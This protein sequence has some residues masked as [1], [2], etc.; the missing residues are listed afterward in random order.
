VALVAVGGS[1]VRCG[2]ANALDIAGALAATYQPNQGPHY[3]YPYTRLVLE[4]L[5]A[6][7]CTCAWPQAAC[8]GLRS[9]AGTV[10][11]GCGCGAAPLSDPDN[12]AAALCVCCCLFACA[13]SRPL[14]AA[15]PSCWH[16]TLSSTWATQ[17][18]APHAA[19]HTGR[20]GVRSFGGIRRSASGAAL[21]P[22]GGSCRCPRTHMLALRPPTPLPRD[23]RLH[24]CL[25]ADARLQRLHVP[26]AGAARGA[27]I[28]AS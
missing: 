18:G 16:T 13:H 26:H 9:M 10:L 19:R 17:Q 11:Q 12:A 20:K 14:Q 8:L 23:P 7:A 27:R 25:Q 1:L 28:P 2:T 3:Y 21:R 5:A 24:A 22:A 15:A 4:G 6:G